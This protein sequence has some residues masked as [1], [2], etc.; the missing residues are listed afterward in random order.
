G[1]VS[2]LSQSPSSPAALDFVPSEAYATTCIHNGHRY[3]IGETFKASDGCN[4]CGCKNNGRIVCTT[5]PCNEY[6][7]EEGIVQQADVCDFHG[8]RYA[9]GVVF[10]HQDKCNNCTC[11]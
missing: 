3:E 10:K 8:K 6:K 2:T 11:N 5:S 9:I 7:A 1:E 4:H